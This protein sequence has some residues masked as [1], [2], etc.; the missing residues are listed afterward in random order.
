MDIFTIVADDTT[1]LKGRFWR[2]DNERAVLQIVHGASEYSL[3]Y[4]DFA[5]WLRQ[6]GISVYALDNRGHGLNQAPGTD[7]VYLRAGDGYKMA[8][9]VI[10]L[11]EK[12]RADHPDKPIILLGHSMGSFIARTAAAQPNPYAKY[13]FV[14]SGLQDPLLL[15]AGLAATRAVRLVKDNRAPSRLLDNVTFNNLR[16]SMRKKGLIDEDHEWLTSDSAQGDKNRDDA[17]LGQKFTVGA[18]RAM[19]DLIKQ[20]QSLATFKQTDKPILFLTGLQDPVSRYGR[21]IRHLARRYRK[22]GNSEVTEIYYPGMRH[23]VLN[24]A[25]RL[26]VY[27]DVLAFIED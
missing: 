25:D 6:R 27:R 19:F 14:G 12:I 20:A 7:K 8:G 21:T 22:Y 2:A 16:Q 18:Y 10:A 17:V 26:T 23:E 3:R 24:E 15:R 13:I 1:K 4:Q 9:D 5:D 11:G